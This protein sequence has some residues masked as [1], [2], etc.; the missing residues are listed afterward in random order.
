MIEQKLTMD[1]YEQMVSL[2]MCDADSVLTKAEFI[3]LC[4]LR[5]D[6][7]TPEL[8]TAI[9]SRFQAL[10]QSRDGLL[11]VVELVRS[12]EDKP[13]PFDGGSKTDS[14]GDNGNGV[15]YISSSVEDGN[16]GDEEQP[17]PQPNDTVLFTVGANSKVYP[18]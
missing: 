15:V 14:N 13:E 12:D 8:V 4:A 6:A 16:R 18:L 5:L 1:E 17:K 11:N 2:G 10:D 3:V 9:R 7:L